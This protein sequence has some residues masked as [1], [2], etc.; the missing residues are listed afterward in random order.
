MD[1]ETTSCA[2]WVDTHFLEDEQKRSCLLK[3][4]RIITCIRKMTLMKNMKQMHV[5]F[6]PWSVLIK[7]IMGLKKYKFL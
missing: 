3:V 7:E 4:N 1:V 6:F 2:Y 5:V